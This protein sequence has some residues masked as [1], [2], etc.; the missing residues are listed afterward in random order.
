MADRR[1]ALVGNAPG[2]GDISASVDA[3]DWVVRFNN[4]RGFGAV[5]GSAIHEL[6][7]INCGGQMREWLDDGA[8]L[9]RPHVAAAS[10]I[11][12]PIATETGALFPPS[13]EPES[14]DEQNYAAAASA[15]FRA[16]GKS[17]RVLP[18]SAYE[19]A[20]ADLGLLPLGPDTKTPSTGFLAIHAALAELPA[21][22]T[23]ELWGFGFAG[24]EG[25]PFDRERAFVERQHRDRLVWH[26]PQD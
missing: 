24:W 2:T 4:A 16:A 12:L 8:F 18:A 11:T 22:A 19:A 21:D 7:L 13:D 3:A 5:T 26:R 9:S 6:Y 25:H 1:I 10:R 14:E 15:R 17:V 23:L 20:C